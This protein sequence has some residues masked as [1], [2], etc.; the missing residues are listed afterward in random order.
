[1]LITLAKLIP[2]AVAYHATLCVMAT[3]VL[4]VISMARSSRLMMTQ[5]LGSLTALVAGLLFL[6]GQHTPT[7]E[8]FWAQNVVS[9]ALS[10][11]IGAV[12]AVLISSLVLPTL[13]N[14]EV[15][16]VQVKLQSS[17]VGLQGLGQGLGQV[18]RVGSILDGSGCIFNTSS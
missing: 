6:L 16:R 7:I 10:V 14:D 18:A 2:H 13:A 3:A 5:I 17:G 15:G 8:Q 4:A 11:L 1:M 12:T 9:L